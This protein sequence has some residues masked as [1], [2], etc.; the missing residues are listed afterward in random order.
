M[1]GLESAD[2][3]VLKLIRKR[4]EPQDVERAVKL[5]RQ[6]GIDIRLAIM[7][8]NPGETSESIKQTMAFVKRVNPDLLIAN[9]TTPYPGTEMYAWADSLGYLKSK[10]WDDYTLA[11]CVMELPTIS[12]AEIE[13]AYRKV[14][15]EFYFRPAYLTRRLAKLTTIDGLLLHLRS[16]RALISFG[17]ARKDREQV[18]RSQ[19]VGISPTQR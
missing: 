12:C 5:T 8:G 15:R 1:Y 9:I 2:R 6:A 17:N 4:F 16:L 3:K 10:N 11:Q 14:Y 7:L 19:P 18:G 13:A